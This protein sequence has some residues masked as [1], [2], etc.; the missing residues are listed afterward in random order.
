MRGSHGKTGDALC[1]NPTWQSLNDCVTCVE[2]QFAAPARRCQFSIQ[3][4]HPSNLRKLNRWSMLEV[5]IGI[6]QGRVPLAPRA[7]TILATTVH[8][9]DVNHLG[10]VAN[11]LTMLDLCRVGNPA[12]PFGVCDKVTESG[13]R[14]KHDPCQWVNPFKWPSSSFLGFRMVF[15]T[16]TSGSWWQNKLESSAQ[17]CICP[18]LKKSQAKQQQCQIC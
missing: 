2:F 16:S 3:H 12:F 7:A 17:S 15:E 10:F 4:W 13:S 5:E 9:Q 14:P 6:P 8:G 1:G 18:R 11:S